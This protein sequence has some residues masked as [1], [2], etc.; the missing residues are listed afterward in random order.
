MIS[1]SIHSNQF[2]GQL[3]TNK[4]CQFVSKLCPF[5]R[6]LTKSIQ[7]CGIMLLLPMPNLAQI[8]G[9]KNKFTL[10]IEHVNLSRT[11]GQRTNDDNANRPEIHPATASHPS[12]NMGNDVSMNIV[13]PDSQPIKPWVSSFLVLQHNI[14]HNILYLN[15][16]PSP[17][18]L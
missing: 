18:L 8:Q 13:V 11:R 15:R 16:W 2:I 14:K 4:C 17:P 7:I 1:R 10:L 5:C 9:E 3:Q 6:K 12:E